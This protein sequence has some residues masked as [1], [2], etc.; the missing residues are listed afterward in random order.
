MVKII[1]RNNYLPP[2][3]EE[4]DGEILVE[5]AGYIPAD[6]KIESMIDA[7]RRLLDF[8]AGYEFQD[9]EEIPD[10]YLDPTRDPGFDLADASSL[11]A[12]TL[13]KMASKAVN[14]APSEPENVPP[15]ESTPE[16][17]KTVLE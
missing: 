13:Q 11:Q 6:R 5:T 14:R 17:K 3:G 8:R 9:G 7:G 10:D 2:P 16:Q 15:V 4:N 1:D 12:S